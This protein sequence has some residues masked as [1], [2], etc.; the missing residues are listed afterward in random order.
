MVLSFSLREVDWPVII[1]TP[2][3]EV[4]I[5]LGLGVWPMLSQ[6]PD[7]DGGRETALLF[8][9]GYLSVITVKYGNSQGPFCYHI[10]EGKQ[11]KAEERKGESGIGDGC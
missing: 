8:I 1:P 11:R 5:G 4:E 2:P 6:S 10:E 7:T 9:P 3:P